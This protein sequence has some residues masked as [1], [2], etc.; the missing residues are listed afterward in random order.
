MW[1][2]LGLDTKQSST[3]LHGWLSWIK[4]AKVG[5]YYPTGLTNEV[6]ARERVTRRQPSP[7]RG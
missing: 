1:S 6:M 7:A 4:P 5:A 3:G 2:W